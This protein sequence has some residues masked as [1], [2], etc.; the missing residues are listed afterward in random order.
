MKELHEEGEE[1]IEQPQVL[2]PPIQNQTNENQ[3]MIY[4]PWT[5][6]LEP[7][8]NTIPPLAPNSFVPIHQAIPPIHQRK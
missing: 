6:E 1:E 8:L 4:N 2:T 5:R 7:I 3:R